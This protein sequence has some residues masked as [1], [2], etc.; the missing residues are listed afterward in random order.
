MTDALRRRTGSAS[1]SGSCTTMPAGT[2][3]SHRRDRPWRAGRRQ[4]HRGDSEGNSN[5]AGQP[6]GRRREG[7]RPPS[8]ARSARSTLRAPA[9]RRRPP[10]GRSGIAALVA[11][12]RPVDRGRTDAGAKAMPAATTATATPMGDAIAADGGGEHGHGRR[13]RRPRARRSAPGVG[14]QRGDERR[15]PHRPERDR[16]R[17]PD[18][19]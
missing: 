5:R 7:E 4:R 1:V 14:D 11:V 15:R 9:R 12:S 18:A 3:T 13:G 6:A 19:V 16:R 8:V 2:N 10:G 17:R